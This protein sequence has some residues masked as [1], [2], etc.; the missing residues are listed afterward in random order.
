MTNNTPTITRDGVIGPDGS[1]F[2]A[3]TFG[4]PA[5]A[6]AGALAGVRNRILAEGGQKTD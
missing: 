1:A 5:G 3:T 4:R 6:M 2:S